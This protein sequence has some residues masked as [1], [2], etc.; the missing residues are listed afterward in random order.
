MCLID[1]DM[2]PEECFAELC[3]DGVMQYCLPYNMKNWVSQLKRRSLGNGVA[4][5]VITNK[6]PAHANPAIRSRYLSNL[7]TRFLI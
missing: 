1:G 4:H 3:L 5:C 6:G 7:H 2:M